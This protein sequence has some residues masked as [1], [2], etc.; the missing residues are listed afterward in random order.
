M[1]LKTVKSEGK[2][3]GEREGEREGKSERESERESEGK[4]E[5]KSERESEGG[6]KVKGKILFCHGLKDNV[7][8]TAGDPS[9]KDDNARFT[10]VPLKVLYELDIHVYNYYFHLRF[11]YNSDLRISTAGKHIFYIIDKIKV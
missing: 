8:V 3:E 4:S 9:C 10:T 2:N 7:S 5:R 1:C 6:G 11:L